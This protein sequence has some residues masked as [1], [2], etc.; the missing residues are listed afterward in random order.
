MISMSRRVRLFGHAGHPAAISLVVDQKTLAGPA[1]DR[2]W[3]DGGGFRV[4][5]PPGCGT[6]NRKNDTNRRP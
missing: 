4:C 2:R 3:D 5:H 6:R 1:K